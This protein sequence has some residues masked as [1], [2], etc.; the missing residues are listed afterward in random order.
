MQ[1]FTLTAFIIALLVGFNDAPPDLGTASACLQQDTPA[2]CAD[3]HPEAEIICT[4]SGECWAEPDGCT[5]DTECEGS[6]Q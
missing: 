3:M 6:A 5:T 1:Y 2:H 4:A